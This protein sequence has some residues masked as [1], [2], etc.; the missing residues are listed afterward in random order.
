MHGNR[1][2]LSHVALWLFKGS[3]LTSTDILG[4]DIYGKILVLISLAC[5]VEAFDLSHG[6]C[7]LALADGGNKLHFYS[8]SEHASVGHVYTVTLPLENTSAGLAVK[9]RWAVC[10]SKLRKRCAALRG[11]SNNMQ[12]ML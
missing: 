5:H 6:L 10:T 8:L 11:S 9:F 1:Q 12:A 4:H 2:R 3:L 7:S